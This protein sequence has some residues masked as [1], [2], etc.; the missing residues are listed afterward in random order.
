M[1]ARAGKTSWPFL[2]EISMGTLGVKKTKKTT[3]LELFNIFYMNSVL[4]SGISAEAFI[5]ASKYI[6]IFMMEKCFW[7]YWFWFM[8]NSFIICI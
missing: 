1:L 2:K 7:Y 3:G 4:S 8:I 6:Y 5:I